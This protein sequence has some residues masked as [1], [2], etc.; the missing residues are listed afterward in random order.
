M[1]SRKCG[2]SICLWQKALKT[3]IS[4]SFKEVILLLLEKDFLPGFLPEHSF[5]HHKTKSWWWQLKCQTCSLKTIVHKRMGDV[6]V[7]MSSQRLSPPTYL[8]GVAS[9]CGGMMTT[10][11]VTEFRRRSIICSWVRVATATLQ[12]STKRLPWRSPACQA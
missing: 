7:I 12:I 2:I 11:T 5:L 4:F 8:R 1:L 6:R 3:Q 9:S 10:R